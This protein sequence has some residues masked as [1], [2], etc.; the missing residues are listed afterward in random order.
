MTT[1]L[2]LFF[3]L[4][5]LTAARGADPPPAPAKA[6]RAVPVSV[7]SQMFQKKAS[8]ATAKRLA[9]RPF[10]VSGTVRAVD[11]GPDGVALS[12][13][14]PPGTPADL[15]GCTVSFPKAHPSFKVAC[16]RWLVRNEWALRASLLAGSAMTTPATGRTSPG[17]GGR[18]GW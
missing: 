13:M 2:P 7:L 6:I 16:F 9:G 12:L 18:A 5:V 17:S 8:G 1:R 3:A 4:A 10:T 15:P 11:E 14:G